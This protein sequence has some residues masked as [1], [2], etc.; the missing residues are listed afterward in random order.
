MTNIRY[1]IQDLNKFIHS[2][3]IE[4][5]HYHKLVHMLYEFYKLKTPLYYYR[6]ASKLEIITKHNVDQSTIDKPKAAV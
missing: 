6:P 5:I 3:T 1:I 2:Q 4:I